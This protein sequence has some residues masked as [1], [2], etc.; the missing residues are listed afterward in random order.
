MIINK[1]Y[2]HIW[3]YK[4][5]TPGVWFMVVMF[6]LRK[7]S[8]KY[9]HLPTGEADK[10]TSHNMILWLLYH[11]RNV[12]IINYPLFIEI[13]CYKD[14]LILSK[15]AKK[16]PSFSKNDIKLLL[17]PMAEALLDDEHKIRVDNKLNISL[18][19][20]WAPRHG[21]AFA[22]F[23]N[24]LKQLCCIREPKSDMKWRKYIQ[25]IVRNGI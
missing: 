8:K 18:A 3:N 24:P 16:I 2:D 4:D 1:Y 25:Q 10:S 21:K 11:H 12:F 17:T 9:K 14:C 13:G 5:K 7:R 6:Y 23:I 22:E 20:K 15:R 19:S